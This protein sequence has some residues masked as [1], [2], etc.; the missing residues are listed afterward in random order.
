MRII[1]DKIQNVFVK[2]NIRK[3]YNCL[4]IRTDVYLSCNFYFHD[5]NNNCYNKHFHLTKLVVDYNINNKKKN[6]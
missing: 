4:F 6:K 2:T 1:T 3:Y 5:N